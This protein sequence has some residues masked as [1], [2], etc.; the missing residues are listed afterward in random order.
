MK[1][2]CYPV[3]IKSISSCG[4][5]YLIEDYNGNSDYFPKSTVF[6]YGYGTFI[7]EWILEKKSITYSCKQ[8]HWYNSETRKIKPEVIIEVI[9]K[10]PEKII[11]D[12]NSKIDE[13]LIKQSIKCN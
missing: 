9:K 7:A 13:S 8:P 2:R 12:T 6:D 4:G 1:T 11:F 10:V 5:A 3:K